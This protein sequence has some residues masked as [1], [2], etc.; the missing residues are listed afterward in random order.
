MSL[1]H[2]KWHFKRLVARHHPCLGYTILK[3]EAGS[4][5]AEAGEAFE[6]SLQQSLMSDGGKL[7]RNMNQR[8]RFV[9][10]LQSLMESN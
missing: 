4:S 5:R 2:R 3:P 10:M 9:V 1:K 8:L 6:R 7:L